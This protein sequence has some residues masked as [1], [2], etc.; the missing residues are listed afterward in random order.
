MDLAGASG[1]GGINSVRS[2]M[3]THTNARLLVRTPATLR[4]VQSECA[5]DNDSKHNPRPNTHNTQAESDRLMKRCVSC[6]HT[7]SHTHRDQCLNRCVPTSELLLSTEIIGCTYSDRVCVVSQRCL[8]PHWSPQGRSTW[9]LCH[10]EC[11]FLWINDR[12]VIIPQ[13]WT[14]FLGWGW[15]DVAGRD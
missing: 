2:H 13:G 10:K 3:W 7:N 6:T 11:E 1:P 8:P 12:S 5:E 4:A 9:N 14:R 15:A